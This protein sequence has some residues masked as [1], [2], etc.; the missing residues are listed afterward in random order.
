MNALEKT[1]YALVLEAR[2][3]LQKMDD[4]LKEDWSTDQPL[5]KADNQSDND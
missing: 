3:I 1:I 4:I 2:D 5:E